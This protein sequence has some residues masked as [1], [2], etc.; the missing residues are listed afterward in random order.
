MCLTHDHSFLGVAASHA[1]LGIDGTLG[2]CVLP[3]FREAGV[4]AVGLVVGGDVPFLYLRDRVSPS[5]Q[6]P[7]WGTLWMIDRL[8]R[9]IASI[10]DGMRI[11]LESADLERARSQQ[12]IAL[13]LLIEGIAPFSATPETDP[14][15]ALRT[16]HRLG[17]RG[18]QIDP[19]PHSP[20]FQTHEEGEPPKALSEIG[21]AFLAEMSE[22]GMVIDVSH[23]REAT[24]LLFEIAERSEAPLAC[25]HANPRSVSESAWDAEDDVFRAVA[26]TGGVCGAKPTSALIL[27]GEQRPVLDS[28]IAQIRHVIDLVGAERVALGPDVLENVMEALPPRL[29]VEGLES[30]DRLPRLT[31]ALL[32]AEIPEDT[33]MGFLGGNWLR[34]WE[35]VLR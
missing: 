12:Q 16:L 27:P 32:D 5:M 6:H 31:E 21:R 20:L 14:I 4:D 2:S 11:C 8:H 7:W 34:L 35:S 23:F 26:A 1:L 13:V 9:E 29:F 25:S 18:V 22:L 24:P 30:L 17:I 10:S 19:L 15:V 28:V 33:V 3:T